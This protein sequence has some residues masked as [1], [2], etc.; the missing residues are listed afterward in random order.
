MTSDKSAYR[1]NSLK[2]VEAIN[3]YTMTFLLTREKIIY[4]GTHFIHNYL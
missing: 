2:N 1:K 4:I 3:K